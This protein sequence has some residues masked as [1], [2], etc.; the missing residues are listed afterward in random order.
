M[1][2]G[3][4]DA[5]PR[6]PAKPQR[7]ALEA[8]G[9]RHIYERNGEKLSDFV[10]G[11]RRGDTIVVDGLDRLARRRA[12]FLRAFSE[13]EKRG[14][15]VMDARTGHVVT[16]TC[17]TLVATAFSRMAGELRLPTNRAA[18]ALGEL[19]GR[20]KAK[21][22]RDQREIWTDK[23]IPTNQ[24]AADL[25]GVSTRTLFRRFGSSG[26]PSGFPAYLAEKRKKKPSR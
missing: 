1:L 8:A 12:D 5:T 23:N 13:I 22:Q 10:R 19:G 11:L 4:I 9:C 25:I 3:W 15:Q 21:L 20:P 6:F 26:R 16:S 24:E 7:A 17:V 2:R 14:C 18:K